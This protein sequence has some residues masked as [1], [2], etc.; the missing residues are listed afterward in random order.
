MYNFNHLYYFYVTAKAGGVIQAAKHLRISQPSLSSQLKVLENSLSVKLFKRVGRNNHLT[1]E[2]STIFGYCRRMF[3][4]SEEMTDS[5]SNRLPSAARRLHVGVSEEVDRPFVVEVVSRFL[6]EHGLEKRPKISVVSGHHE[7]LLERLRFRELDVIVTAAPTSDPDLESLAR[8]EVPVVLACSTKWKLNT[9][10]RNPKLSFA[11]SAIRGGDTAQWLVP[12]SRYRFRSEIDRFLEKN[13]IK[14]R[15][16]F[17]SDV[18]ASLV[19]SV[20]DGVGLAFLPVLYLAR[21]IR[22]KSIRA[23]GPK[24]GYWRYGVW[25]VGHSQSHGDHLI[26]SFSKAFQTICRTQSDM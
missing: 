24:D 21:E 4:I 16:T 8:A 14:T 10:P 2:G 20:A 25:L 11:L 26:Q 17:E 6:K 15:I 7:Q 23:I 1:E 9:Y 3:E 5:I 12:S 19:R 18:M 13:G 22:E